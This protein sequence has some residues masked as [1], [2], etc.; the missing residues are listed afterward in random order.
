MTDIQDISDFIQTSRGAVELLK[1]ALSVMPKGGDRDE[2]ERK[3]QSAEDVLRRRD[4]KL[5]QELG[6]HLRDCTMPPQVMPWRKRE[7]AHMYPNP[8]CGRKRPKPTASIE[9]VL[10]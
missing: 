6:M 4:A 3:I 2:A 9:L 8:E 5:A 1:S 7:Q 10:G